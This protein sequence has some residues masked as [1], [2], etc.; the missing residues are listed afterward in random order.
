[1]ESRTNGLVSLSLKLWLIELTQIKEVR[2]LLA[3]RIPRAQ[4]PKLV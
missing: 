2:I 4:A 3:I 1:M